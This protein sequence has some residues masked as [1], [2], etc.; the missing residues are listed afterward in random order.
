[1][2]MTQRTLLA[3]CIKSGKN[4][5]ETNISTRAMRILSLAYYD[6]AQILPL[7]AAQ[8]GLNPRRRESLCIGQLASGLNDWEIV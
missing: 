8:T 6:T 5:G 3:D 7:E 1:M 2:R 4:Y